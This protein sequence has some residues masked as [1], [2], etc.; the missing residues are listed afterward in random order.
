MLKLLFISILLT[1]CSTPRQDDSEDI[2]RSLRMDFAR[3]MEC[4][5]VG[6]GIT[7]CENIE[8]VCYN[9]NCFFKHKVSSKLNEI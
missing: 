2:A 3:R 4:Q 7:R 5:P 6:N 1:G 8:A 9:N